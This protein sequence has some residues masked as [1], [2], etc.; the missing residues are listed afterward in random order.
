MME[1]GFSAEILAFMAFFIQPSRQLIQWFILCFMDK[2][3]CILLAKITLNMRTSSHV[4]QD[5]VSNI[6][7]LLAMND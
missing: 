3:L 4:S 1:T 5:N 2:H 6:C 7:A